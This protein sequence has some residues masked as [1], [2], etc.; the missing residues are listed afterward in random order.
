MRRD[1]CVKIR[2][3]MV[4][5]SRN[6]STEYA[7]LKIP[8]TL[9]VKNRETTSEHKLLGLQILVFG[10]VS[11]LQYGSICDDC[12]KK[13]NR[14]G[15]QTLIDFHSKSDVILPLRNSDDKSICIY[16]NFHCYPKHY[17]NDDSGYRCVID[18]NIIG[19]I[20]VTHCHSLVTSL[21]V[22]L[23]DQDQ[24]DSS[25]VR[26]RLPYTFNIVAKR[27]RDQFELENGGN[28]PDPP[29]RNTRR[30]APRDNGFVRTATSCSVR[31]STQ[32]QR[33]SGSSG[34][35]DNFESIFSQTNNP[36]L[37]PTGVQDRVSPAALA[38][39]SRAS[40]TLLPSATVEETMDGIDAVIEGTNP[41]R[42]PTTGGLDIWIYGTNL[43]DGS[44]PLYARFG[45]NVTR[46]VSVN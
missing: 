20:I 15:S 13:E 46:V 23:C 44:R 14:P 27:T 5:I 42:G 7:G 38:E 16:F 45:D 37:L 24:Q 12:Q 28:L 3:D 34:G 29:R 26:F 32:D 40:R 1:A 9:S 4:E 39:S 8:C 31:P 30:R 22:L 21:E 18:C 2:F 6:T 43:P 10:T 35:L 11:G 25:T 33:S 36:D 41:G 19:S 17:N